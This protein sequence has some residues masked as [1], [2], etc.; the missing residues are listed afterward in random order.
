[1]A[2]NL[3]RVG[4]HHYCLLDGSHFGSEALAVAHFKAEHADAMVAFLQDVLKGMAC[5]CA[6][7]AL[8]CTNGLAD[9][10]RER[11]GGYFTKLLYSPALYPS[12][13]AAAAVAPDVLFPS[14]PAKPLDRPGGAAAA[15][16]SGSGAGGGA[17]AKRKKKK[18]K[19][20]RNAANKSAADDD[21]G[22]GE[23]V[24]SAVAAVVPAPTMRLAPP[25]APLSRHA[26]VVSPGRAERSAD[27][28][29]ATAVAAA[30]VRGHSGAA[31]SPTDKATHVARRGSGSRAGVERS[32]SHQVGRGRGCAVVACGG[33]SQRGL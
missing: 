5:T 25:E 32:T 11:M 13:D 3:H 26:S 12:P 6:R 8:C 18:K 7:R 16:G 23:D 19:K 27:L 24:A 4:T 28:A 20:K 33:T 14:A 22:G 1:M 29:V 21:G 2:D 30:Q 17:G 15:D 9:C 10:E 31:L